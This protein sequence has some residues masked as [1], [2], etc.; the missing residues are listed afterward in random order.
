MVELLM[1]IDRRLSGLRD[2]H[3]R[4][5]HRPVRIVMFSD[6][7]CGNAKIHHAE[8]IDHLLRDAGLRVV[9]ALDASADVVAP[10]FGLVNYGALF[11]QDADRAGAAATAIARHDAVEIAAFSPGPATVEVVSGS[12]RA[13]V[14]WRGAPGAI[15]YAYDDDGGDPLRL[16]AV[17]R[18]LAAGGRLDE[19]GFA[20]DDEW[21]Q[22]TA[23]AYYPDALRRLGQALTG[24][25]VRSRASV[26]YSLG[27]TWAGGWHSAV[28]GAWVRGGR[29]AGTHGGLDRESSLGFYLVSDLAFALPSPTRSDVVL[30]R[31][32]DL[33]AGSGPST[34]G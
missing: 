24:D 27:P 5:R 8:G 16:A 10:K 15:R 11:L 14:R 28:V 13:R 21:L 18:Q 9:D 34:L 1:E 2:R 17:R 12:G 6:H 3:Q 20:A 22:G 4:S 30:A 25:R 23:S 7:G 26:L 32:A 33:V 29:L 19:D 31:F